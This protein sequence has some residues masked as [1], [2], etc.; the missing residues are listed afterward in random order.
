MNE[1][2]IQML[3]TANRTDVNPTDV[4]YAAARILVAH[5]K[6]SMQ[7]SLDLVTL[8]VLASVFHTSAALA[9]KGT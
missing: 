6:M 1:S 7:E 8:I 5:T 3:D 2:K 9:K 4:E